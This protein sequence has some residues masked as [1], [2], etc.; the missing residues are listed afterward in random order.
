MQPLEVMAQEFQAYKNGGS[1]RVSKTLTQRA[2][3]WFVIFASERPQSANT[4]Q[5]PADRCSALRE[6]A[7]SARTGHP[8]H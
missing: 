8:F 2:Q 7:R 4:F 5:P 6:S 3:Y 1:T